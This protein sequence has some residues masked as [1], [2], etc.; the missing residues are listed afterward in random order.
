MPER[1]LLLSGSVLVL[2]PG[3]MIG[4]VPIA[5]I[6]IPRGGVLADGTVTGLPA[7]GDPAGWRKADMDTLCTEWVPGCLSDG[8]CPGPEFLDFF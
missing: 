2:K 4:G 5:T 3:A 6:V 1:A 8:S 7:R